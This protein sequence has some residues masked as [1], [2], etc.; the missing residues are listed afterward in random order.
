M[1]ARYP[2]WRGRLLTYLGACARTP[3]APG[4]HD[5]ALFAAGAVAAMTGTDLAAGWRGRYGSLADG[6][7]ALR[8]AGYP[9]QVALTA[10]HLPEW[11]DEDGAPWPMRAGVGDVAVVDGDGGWP[12][13]GIVQ[14]PGIYVL[15][16]D[17]LAT[18][19]L[20]LARRAFLV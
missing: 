2:D 9:D 19:P 5:C 11:L 3:F 6:L 20:T 13:L 1:I 12:A 10:A 7:L 16:P 4:A 15:Q 17:G 14:G 18:L 8:A